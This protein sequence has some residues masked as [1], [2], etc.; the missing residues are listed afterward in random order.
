MFILRDHRLKWILAEA[1]KLDFG[2]VI[3]SPDSSSDRRQPFLWWVMNY[4]V[5]IKKLYGNWNVMTLNQEYMDV[6]S[7]YA[8]IIRR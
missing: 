6:L 5:N 4:V 3:E 8:G 1:A 2:I 7:C